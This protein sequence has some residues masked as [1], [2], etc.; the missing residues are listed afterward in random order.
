[1]TPTP[2]RRLPPTVTAVVLAYG[3]EPLLEDCVAAILASTGV[4]ADVVLVDNGCTTS[5]VADL[6]GRP[7]V[8]VLRPARNTGFAGGCNL[9]AGRAT[10]DVLALVNGDAVVRPDALARLAAALEDPTVGLAS[11]SLRLH[12]RPEVMNSAG[13]PVHYLGLSWAGGLGEPAAAHATVQEVASATGAALAVRR[14]LWERLGGF[15]EEMF[16]YCEDAE[17]S[18]RC[19]QQGLRVVYV[20]DAVVLHRYEFS[21]NPRKLY[22]LE[23]NRLLLLLTLYERRTLLVLAPALLGLEL[24][25]LLVALRQGWAREKARGWWWLLRHPSVVRR[26][27]QWVQAARRVPDRELAGLLTA[28]FEPGAEAGVSAPAA[29]TSGSRAYWS[30]ARRLMA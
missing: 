19:W 22:L 24:A 27:R 30:V 17:L 23:R 8:T 11:G 28:R 1:M 6:E 14:E 15:W 13:N 2:P 7:G 9:G 29:L 16:A 5:A 4:V 21:R 20:P 25:V 10:G 18:L 12:D 26:R 3:P